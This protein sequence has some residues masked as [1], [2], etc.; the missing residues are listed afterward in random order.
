MKSRENYRSTGV[1]PSELAH[2]AQYFHQ[3][4][5]FQF[6]DPSCGI[7]VYIRQLSPVRK[8]VLQAELEQLL[9]RWPG[10]DGRA[11]HNAW[12]RLGAQWSPQNARSFLGQAIAALEGKS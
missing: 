3:D 11:L 8:V 12:L 5:G 1:H 6:S 2:F 4:F 10:R 9:A 7:D